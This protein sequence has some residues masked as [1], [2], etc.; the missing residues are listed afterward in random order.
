MR[1]II[2]IVVPVYN[3]ENYVSRSI[4]SALDQTY[5]EFEIIVVDD[6]STDSSMEKVEEF[7]DSRI[8][9]L[10]RSQ[11]GPGGYAA[12]NYGIRE[13][14]G[15]WIA[16]LDADDAWFP[17]HLAQS[18]RIANEFPEISLISAARMSDMDGAMK[19]D[20]FAKQFIS[21]GPQI[22]YLSDYLEFACKGLRA[23]GT[24]SIL[25]KR[26]ALYRNSIFPEGRAER[27]GDLYT[28]VMLIARMK[29]MVWSPHVASISY[30][31]ASFVSR[32]SV[33]SMRLFH[34]MVSDLEPYID[35]C[36]SKALKKYV[37]RMVK[38]AWLENKKVSTNIEVSELCRSFYW[39]VDL[40]YCCKWFLISLLPFDVLVSLH[41]RHLSSR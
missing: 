15:S 34:E 7:K 20:P 25:I 35:E 4:M 13:A 5:T 33:P 16:F 14:R 22:L 3:K 23:M 32:N 12:R 17:E 31:Q 10:H 40:I 6:A 1:P 41:K 37:N 21:Q 30:R 27:S 18:M 19:L 9:V 38:Y 36:Q 28:W 11:P 8:R 24:N 26:E 29:L 2:S 39:D